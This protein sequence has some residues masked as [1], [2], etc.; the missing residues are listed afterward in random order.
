[1]RLITR[2]TLA[3]GQH[4]WPHVDCSGCG[5]VVRSAVEIAG[6]KLCLRCL[7]RAAKLMTRKSG[8]RKVS[9]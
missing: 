2:A 4:V 6:A 5:R 9:K 3:N 1:M 8:K 7:N